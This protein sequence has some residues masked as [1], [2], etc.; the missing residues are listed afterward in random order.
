MV[1]GEGIKFVPISGN[2]EGLEIYGKELDFL[3]ITT[4][5]AA[6]SK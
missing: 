2:N 4:V 5:T 6:L 1:L 3:K